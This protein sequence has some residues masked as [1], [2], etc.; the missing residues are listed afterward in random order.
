[1]SF[2]FFICLRPKRY[3]GS[4]FNLIYGWNSSVSK[5]PAVSW[6]YSGNKHAE[7]CGVCAMLYECVVMHVVVAGLM[8]RHCPHAVCPAVWFDAPRMCAYAGMVA[9][10]FRVCERC[11]CEC[12]GWRVRKLHVQAEHDRMCTFQLAVG[13]PERI[14]MWQRPHCDLGE[15]GTP[16]QVGCVCASVARLRVHARLWHFGF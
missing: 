7:K 13:T 1:M 14:P 3:G 11:Q 16:G 6:A 9:V 2:I 4:V 5:R 15:P 12:R 8:G 10:G